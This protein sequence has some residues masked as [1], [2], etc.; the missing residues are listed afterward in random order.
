MTSACIQKIKILG[1]IL[2][3]VDYDGALRKI[4]GFLKNSGTAVI[5]TPNAEIIM[6][7]KKNEALKGAVNG[8]D[9][10]F[11]DGIGVMLASRIIGNPLFGRTA[12]FDLMMKM[13]EMA[14]RRNLSVFLLG[15]KPGVA[16]DAASNIKARFPGIIIAGAHHGYFDESSEGRII[17]MING[18]GAR[19]LL[20]AMGAPK[21]EIFM[22]RNREKLKCSVA[23]GVGGSLD[24]LAG[25]VHR[26]PVFMQ[27]AGL[28]WLYRLVTQPKRIK[29]MSVLPLFLVEVML[30]RFR[31]FK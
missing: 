20:V 28:E 24:V 16:E 18:S 9:L 3:R 21:Q 7:A 2:D 25:R 17:E 6:A 15:G 31:Q 30:D 23:M 12:G 22:I 26:A 14:A 1:T 8:A 19:I 4:E 13:L 10:R 29:R 27:K 11:P 5:V